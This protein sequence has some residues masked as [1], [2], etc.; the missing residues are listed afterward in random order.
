MKDRKFPG[1][2]YESQQE[3]NERND[4]EV[5]NLPVKERLSLLSRGLSF[6]YNNLFLYKERERKNEREEHKS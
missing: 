6:C 3:M 4:K 1:E 2:R 5:S